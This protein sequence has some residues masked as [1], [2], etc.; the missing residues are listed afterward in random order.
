MGPEV[1]SSSPTP[2]RG[3]PSL[4]LLEHLGSH[5]SLWGC[6]GWARL[7]DSPVYHIQFNALID[8]KLG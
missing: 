1:L 4:E 6:G 7:E 2:G 5:A 8:P 3:Q